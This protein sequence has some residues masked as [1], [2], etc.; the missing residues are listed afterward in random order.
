MRW[1]VCVDHM[2]SKIKKNFFLVGNVIY[3]HVLDYLWN[4]DQFCHA[5]RS[6][7]NVFVKVLTHD[8]SLLA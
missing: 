6:R 8:F 4:D 3:S 1:A 5:R 7:V 2:G